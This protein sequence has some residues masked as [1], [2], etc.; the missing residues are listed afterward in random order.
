MTAIA[1]SAA[2]SARFTAS[3][4]DPVLAA[5]QL[6]AELAQIYYEQPNDDTARA[7]V[8][9]APSRGPTTRPSSMP[10]SAR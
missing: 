4:V 5:H 1:S 9:V 2:L 10:S 7:M 3:T 8:A 6:V